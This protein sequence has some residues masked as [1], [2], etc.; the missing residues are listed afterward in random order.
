MWASGWLR[1]PY[2]PQ[3]GVVDTMAS[4]DS[5]PDGRQPVLSRTSRDD[6]SED[7]ARHSSIANKACFRASSATGR[8][9]AKLEGV[10]TRE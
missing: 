9:F 3:H 6:T 5:R 1:L 8:C 4:A 10:L 7:F 2:P